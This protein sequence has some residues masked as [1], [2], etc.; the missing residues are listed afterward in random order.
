MLC[1]AATKEHLVVDHAVPAGERANTADVTPKRTDERPR[2]EAPDPGAAIL[3]GG[4]EAAVR[5]DGVPD[6]S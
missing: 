2:P 3:R 5:R 1:C 6:L 4:D